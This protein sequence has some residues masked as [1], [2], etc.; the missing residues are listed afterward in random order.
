MFNWPYW[1]LH[2][3]NQVK[4]ELHPTQDAEQVS[5]T[6]RVPVRPA[7][8]VSFIWERPNME[9]KMTNIS[10]KIEGPHIVNCNC[11]YGCPCQYMALPT[12]GTC[13]AVVGWRIDKGHY[14]DTTLDGLN[15]VNTYDW[16][17]AIHEGNG[18]MQTIIDERADDAQRAALQAIMQGEGGEPGSTMLK[19]YRTMCSTYHDPVFKPIELE[20]NMEA[21]KGLL[22]VPGMIDTEVEP[23]KNP[24][25]MPV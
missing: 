13:K 4:R 1:R 16:P 2:P 3:K 21:R 9:T 22:R 23:L 25:A 20:I 19:I 24:E 17:N 12:D 11:D 14:G 8:K 6:T 15:A 18:T 10:W 7:W 5:V